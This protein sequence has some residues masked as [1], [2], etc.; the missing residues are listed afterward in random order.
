MENALRILKSVYYMDKPEK[1]TW[2]IKKNM[3]SE[4]FARVIIFLQN[5]GWVNVT[6][7]NEPGP[8]HINLTNR[9]TEYLVNELNR[10]NQN[11]FNKIIALTGCILAL[12]GIFGFFKD[13]DIFDSQTMTVIIYIFLIL[14]IGCLAPIINFIYCWAFKEEKEI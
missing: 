8:F 7:M 1:I 3:S 5:K 14:V 12:I 2:E 10:R 6:K 11:E 9:G 4:E 13:L